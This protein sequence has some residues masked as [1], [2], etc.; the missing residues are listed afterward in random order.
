MSDQ[1]SRAD[2]QGALAEIRQQVAAHW[3]WFL[4]LGLVLVVAGI[5]AIAFPLL[6]TVA[7]KI[8][9]GWVFLVGGIVMIVHAFSASHWHGLI[10]EVL[11][12]ALYAV[13]GA[14][15]A[16]FPLTGIITLT[17]LLAAMFI[18]EGGLEI[19]LALRVRPHEGWGWLLVSGIVA[20]AVGLLIALGLPSSAA[21][22]IGLLAGINLISTGWGFLFL[23][24]AGR[25][26]AAAMATR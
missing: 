17:I 7:V 22:A 24:L 21:W 20:V 25:R 10:W 11:L 26:A 6:S 3:G 1:V 5:A 18:V 9:L 2:L 23:A 14:Y 13:A 16:F 8:A 15:L 4:A 12:G 19:S